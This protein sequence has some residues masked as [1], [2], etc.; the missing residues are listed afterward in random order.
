VVAVSFVLSRTLEN[1]GYSVLDASTE[2]E[3][4]R[5]FEAHGSDIQLILCDMVLSGTYGSELVRRLRGHRRDLKVLFMSGHAREIFAAQ[6][7]LGDEER[8]INK[9]EGPGAIARAVRAALDGAAP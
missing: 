1:L 9:G 8:L 3:F 2:E 6:G 7:L 4:L 5:L